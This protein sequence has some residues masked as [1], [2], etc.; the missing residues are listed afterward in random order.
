MLVTWTFIKSLKKLK[1]REVPGSVVGT[2]DELM[3]EIEKITATKR[4]TYFK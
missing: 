4:R 3:T 1:N 2:L